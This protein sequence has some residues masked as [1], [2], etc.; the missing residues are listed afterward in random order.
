[1]ISLGNSLLRWSLK[2]V[3]WPWWGPKRHNAIKNT[4]WVS[5][6]VHSQF[7]YQAFIQHSK[8]VQMLVQVLVLQP[9]NRLCIP[10]YYL[11]S[12]N[13]ILGNTNFCTLGK[14]HIYLHHTEPAFLHFLRS[15]SGFWY[16]PSWNIECSSL[17]HEVTL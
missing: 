6:W 9:R 13:A 17:W 2:I 12:K 11:R 10:P 7:H 14:A 4:T 1:M 8:A 3:S 16:C 5:L 15:L